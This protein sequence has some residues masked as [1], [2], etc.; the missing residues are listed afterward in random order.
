MFMEYKIEN[1]NLFLYELQQL[2]KIKNINNKD[3]YLELINYKVPEKDRNKDLTNL[4]CVLIDKYNKK[5]KITE[6]NNAYVIESKE[7]TSSNKYINIHIPLVLNNI[8]VNVEKIIKYLLKNKIE[9]KTII[10]KNLKND[11]LVIRVQNKEISDKIIKYINSSKDLSNNMYE[12]NPLYVI[13]NKVYLTTNNKLSYNE[14]LAKYIFNYINECNKKESKVN[15]EDFSSYL[16]NSMVDFISKNDLSKQIKIIDTKEDLPKLLL[17]LEE[18][19]EIIQFNLQDIKNNKNIKETFYS[20]IEK[21]KTISED[22]YK[23]FTKESLEQDELLLEEIINTMTKSYGFDYTQEAIKRYQKNQNSI[24]SI[25]YITRKN[26][27]RNKLKN[28]ISL[29][30]YLNLFEEKELNN[31]INSFKPKSDEQDLVKT[32]EEMILEKVCKETYLSCQIDKRNYS[33]KHQ[34]AISLI[35]M[36]DNNFDSITRK[37][38]ARTLAKQFLSAKKIKNIIEK[39]LEKNGYIIEKESDLYELYATHIENL[40]K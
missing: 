10:S 16:Y 3:I 23:E 29:R 24:S 14:I 12:P 34:V 40:C 39:S 19:T 18:I 5:T 32:T 17:S 25:E 9:H 27:L 36:Q 31:K 37:N 6:C 11:T 21:F 38:D 15:F 7:Q 8:E 30:T 2:S 33:G 20:E 28:K 26:N 1:I 13:D 4:F 35:K 22:K